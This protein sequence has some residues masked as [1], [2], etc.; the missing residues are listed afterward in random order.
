[1]RFLL[2]I[3]AVVFM[4]FLAACG[5]LALLVFTPVNADNVEARVQQSCLII[6]TAQ[7]Y[8]GDHKPAPYSCDCVARAVMTAIGPEHAARIL[9][10]ARQQNSK[11]GGRVFLRHPRK[12]NR[13]P[14]D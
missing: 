11:A 1:M 9:E 5:Y 7:N 13:S 14:V 8:F 12:I 4:A 3:L 10:D 2:L 6:N